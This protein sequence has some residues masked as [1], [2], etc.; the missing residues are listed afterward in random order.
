[1]TVDRIAEIKSRGV[2]AV[3]RAFGAFVSGKRGRSGGHFVCPVCNAATRHTKTS[4]KRGACG[5]RRD[6]A[7]WRCH[8]CDAS[9]DA[10]T[11]AA[12]FVAG[13]RDM[14]G[15]AGVAVITACADRGLCTPFDAKRVAQVRPVYVAPK[16][17][18]PEPEPGIP[19]AELEALWAATLPVNMTLA[20][21]HVLDMAVPFFMSGRGWF[22]P[23]LA[24]LDLVRV[25]PLPDTFLWPTWWPKA[26]TNAYRVVMRA[27][28][29]RGEFVSIH[30]RSVV[31]D[32]TPKS[33]WP[34]GYA[35]GHLFADARGVALLRGDAGDTSKA[36][37]VEG[38]TDLIAL[39]LAVFDAKR[40]DAI[41][42]I[43]SGSTKALGLV[44]W[45]PGIPVVILTDQDEAGEK[46]ATEIRA[47]IPRGVDVRRARVPANAI[48]KAA[49]R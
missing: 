42:G 18:E 6:D 34:K 7:G 20:D 39:T 22:P 15:A 23:L 32:L 29:P 45:P 46:Y 30:G 44:K 41:L 5:I 25:T 14:D 9:G 27:Y 35:A 17:V 37:I 33:R 48:N 21:P 47:A 4:D 1:M 38:M 43:T 12:Y 36:I 24:S 11:L 31:P 16:P 10:V 13:K 3:A 8:Q 19:T 40:T 26:W 49:A 2:S 28:S